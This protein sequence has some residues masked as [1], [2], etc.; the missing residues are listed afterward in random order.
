MQ[1]ALSIKL[2]LN[3]HSRSDPRTLTRTLAGHWLREIGVTQESLAAI[4]DGSERG[5][6]ARG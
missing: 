1:A 3:P 5:W 4:R 2:R 6:T